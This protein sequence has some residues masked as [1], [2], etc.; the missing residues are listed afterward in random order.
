MTK[1]T[2]LPTAERESVTRDV[3]PPL[4]PCRD[5]ITELPIL[6]LYPHSRCNCRCVMLEEHHERGSRR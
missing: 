6:I 3:S 4:V 2:P 5:P 1:L